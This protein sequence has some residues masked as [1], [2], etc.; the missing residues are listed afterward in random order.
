MLEL[1][2]GRASEPEPESMPFGAKARELQK[3]I[4][5]A[6]DHAQK[7]NHATARLYLAEAVDRMRLPLD[8]AEPVGPAG[9][10]SPDQVGRIR[11]LVLMIPTVRHTGGC[12]HVQDL[13]PCNCGA[14]VQRK[15][16]DI[17]GVT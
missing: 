17:I 4:L 6:H 16:L 3:C 14:E 10:L 13:G 15:L 8:Q 2:G 1:L 11:E 7:G 5:K 9:W 12:D